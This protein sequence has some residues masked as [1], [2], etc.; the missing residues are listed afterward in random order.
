MATT[1][2]SDNTSSEWQQ[3]AQEVINIANMRGYD[4]VPVID[5]LSV[6]TEPQEFAKSLMGVYFAVSET[7]IHLAE[8]GEEFPYNVGFALNHIRHFSEALQEMSAQGAPNTHISI[9]CK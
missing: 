1:R 5:F 6:F 8:S 3:H 7:V 9:D 4:W 2:K